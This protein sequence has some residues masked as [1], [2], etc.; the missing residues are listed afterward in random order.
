MRHE[1][2]APNFPRAT[3][4]SRGIVLRRECSCIL[5]SIHVHVTFRR[6]S[7]ERRISLWADA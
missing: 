7:R 5:S 3:H 4:L 6:A 1:N 2:D